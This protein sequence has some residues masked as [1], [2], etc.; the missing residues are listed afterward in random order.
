VEEFV[1][2]EDVSGDGFL[3]NGRLHAVIT[4]KF[5]VG[6]AP[7]GHQLPTHLSADAQARVLAE[8]ERVCAAIGYKDGPLDFDVRVSERMATVIEMSP[9]L[10]GN[11]IPALIAF[12]T[13]FDLVDCTIA[14]ALGERL[15]VPAELP[16]LRPCAS[17]VLG[18]DSDGIVTSVATGAEIEAAVPEVF[19]CAIHV[20]A[21]DR[22]AHFVHSANGI[23]YAL[24]HCG[25][26][27]LYESLANRIERALALQVTSTEQAAGGRI[28]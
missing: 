5:K 4:C 19:D 28:T 12:A 26:P 27:A 1:S 7:R 17:L 6:L 25:E 24:F 10:G 22:V 11:S 8:V 23:G 9:R 18:S 15:S 3:E 21:G 14:Y 13:D 16:V 2:G 20:A